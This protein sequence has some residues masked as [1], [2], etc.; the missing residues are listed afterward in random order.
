M[1]SG[2]WVSWRVVVA[3]ALFALVASGCPGCNEP[4]GDSDFFD[5]GEFG[6]YEFDGE[7]DIEAPDRVLMGEVPIGETATQTAEVKNVGRETLKI[8]EWKLDN[9]EFVLRFGNQLNPPDELE[10]GESVLIGIDF[11]A[12][13]DDEHRGTLTIQSNDPDEAKFDI[14]LFA[15]AKFP[16]LE[17]VPDDVVNFGEVESDERLERIVEIRN[18]SANART[19]FTLLGITGDEDAFS[20]AREPEFQTR[21]L[22]IGESVSVVIAFEPPSP[23]RYTGALEIESDDEF[24]PEHSLELRGVGAEGQCPTPVII[25]ANPERGE[26]EA[27]PTNT[28]EVLPLDTMRL[29]GEQSVAYDDKFID[30]WEWSLISKPQDS[31]AEFSNTNTNPQNELYLDL[32]GDYV[33]ELEVWDN[34]G[35]KSCAAARMTLRA[36]ADED[37]HIQ[38]VWDTPNDPNQNDSSGSDVDVHLLHPFGQ[39]NRTPWDCFWQNLIPD[40]GQSRPAGTDS[41]DCEQDPARQGCQDDPSLDIDDVDGWGPENINLN[42]PEPDTR[43]AVGVH[44]FS[45]HGYSMSFATIRIFIGGVMRAEYRRQRL[46][47]QEFWYVADIDWPSATISPN[48]QVFDS[49]P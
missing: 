47:D 48:G 49:F 9:D 39:W 4:I 41:L 31:A 11:T 28:F 30:R 7:P 20:F 27:R 29:S 46:V 16:C 37:I 40:W 45:D 38:L 2:G 1:Q 13:D 33:V 19:T 42:N 34:E 18:C 21:T 26:A 6:E 15:N 17:T 14:D 36:I 43:Y 23:G 32:A 3:V 24:R 35:V 10:P 5:P 12:A 22:E 25:A 44:Y 8:S